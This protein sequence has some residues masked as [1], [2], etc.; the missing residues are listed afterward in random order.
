MQCLNLWNLRTSPLCLLNNSSQIY[1]IM[2]LRLYFSYSLLVLY[3]MVLDLSWYGSY[4]LLDGEP[5]TP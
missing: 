1:D 4:S 3:Y 2:L 5:E